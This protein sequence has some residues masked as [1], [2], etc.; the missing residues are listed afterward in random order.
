M[1]RWRCAG[2]TYSLPSDPTTSARSRIRAC[3]RTSRLAGPKGLRIRPSQTRSP[4]YG[5][6]CGWASPTRRWRSC[7]R[8][9]PS[10]QTTCGACLSR[11]T[12]SLASL[13]RFH[14]RG[15]PVSQ[16]PYPVWH[17]A[18]AKAEIAGRRV[19]HDFRR[20]AARAYRRS[21]VIEGVVMKI[22]GHETRSISERYNIRNEDDLREAALAVGELGSNG[23]PTAR[24][25]SIAP[26]AS[27]KS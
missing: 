11:T 16:F 6:C 23:K 7:R 8:F 10:R 9:R 18:C 21:G 2:S 27:K 15:L 14:R 1:R 5:A 25:V 20:T 4:S 3:R 12:S 13:T 24:V 19:P 26:A 22:L 17:A